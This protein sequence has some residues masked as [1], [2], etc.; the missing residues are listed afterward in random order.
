MNSN[1]PN[2]PG[3]IYI[4]ES[5]WKFS[6]YKGLG[7]RKCARA[8]LKIHSRHLH[9]PLCGIFGPHSVNVAHYASLIGVQ[10]TTNCD[11][12]LSESNFQARSKAHWGI[13]SHKWELE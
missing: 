13:S 3:R 9:V 10:S 5:G 8:C 4:H 6:P 12:Q 11:A 1:E 2:K 7:R